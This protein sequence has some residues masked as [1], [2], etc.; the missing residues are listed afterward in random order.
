MIDLRVCIVDSNMTHVDTSLLHVRNIRRVISPAHH[1]IASERKITRF[2]HSSHLPV[3]IFTSLEIGT[4]CIRIIQKSIHRP[5][6]RTVVHGILIDFGITLMCVQNLLPFSIIL[7]SRSNKSARPI[8]SQEE[9]R[10]LLLPPN[11]I[12]RMQPIVED[13]FIGTELNSGRKNR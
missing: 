10:R 9:K 13:D 11:L 8:I 5:Q 12:R 2:T 1:S 6:S 4:C 7:R 3:R